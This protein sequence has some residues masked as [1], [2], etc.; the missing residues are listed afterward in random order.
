M[1]NTSDTRTKITHLPVDEDTLKGLME[2]KD[3]EAQDENAFYNM[4]LQNDK[5]IELEV[6]IN[7]TAIAYNMIFTGFLPILPFFIASMIL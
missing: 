3:G 4:R 2:G 1:L 5:R 7:L 6:D